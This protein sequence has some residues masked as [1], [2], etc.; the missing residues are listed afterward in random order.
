M[1]EKKLSE[2][3]MKRLLL[4]IDAIIARGHATREVLEK[5]QELQKELKKNIRKK[6]R[7]RR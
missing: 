5:R 1:P 3:E 6:L 2:E 4:E 7:R